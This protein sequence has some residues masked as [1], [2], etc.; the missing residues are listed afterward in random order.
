[1]A[2][3]PGTSIQRPKMICNGPAGPRMSKTKEPS[4]MLSAFSLSVDCHCIWRYPGRYTSRRHSPIP[5]SSTQYSDATSLKVE[6]FAANPCEYKAIVDYISF[7]G[8]HCGVSPS[9]T[10][11][12]GENGNLGLEPRDMRSCE[13]A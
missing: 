4:L 2:R 9:G 6:R 12:P 11:P 5:C 10:L 7:I 13:S 3:D 8:M 1:M